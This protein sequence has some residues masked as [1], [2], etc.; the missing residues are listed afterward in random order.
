MATLDL[1]PPKPELVEAP[2][3]DD[4]CAPNPVVAGLAPKA[5]LAPKP[6][7]DGLVAIMMIMK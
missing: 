5:E 6:V 3:P 7:V 1:P 2:N 4:G